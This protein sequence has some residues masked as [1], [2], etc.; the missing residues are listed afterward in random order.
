MAPRHTREQ[1]QKN[2]REK[3]NSNPQHYDELTMHMYLA[4]RNKLVRLLDNMNMGDNSMSRIKILNHHRVGRSVG[5]S[6]GGCDRDLLRKKDW[7]ALWC[8]TISCI[9]CAFDPP[10]KLTATREPRRRCQYII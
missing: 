8:F 1:K 2:E 10:V 3:Q 9:Y 4:I 7:C 5:R 6:D